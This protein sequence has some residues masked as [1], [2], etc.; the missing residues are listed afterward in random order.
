MRRAKDHAPFL[1]QVS[2]RHEAV[3]N[4]LDKGEVDAAWHAASIAGEG[5]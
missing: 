5:A 4:L 1:A 2:R 3:C